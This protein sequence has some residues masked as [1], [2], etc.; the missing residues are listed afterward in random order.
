MFV[1]YDW[2]FPYIKARK[3]RYFGHVVRKSGDCSEKEI[4]QGR[5]GRRRKGRPKTSR[6][7][8][9][10]SWTG[11]RRDRLMR[12]VDE[13]LQWRQI[14]HSAANTR[15]I[16][17]RSMTLVEWTEVTR[18]SLSFIR[19][20]TLASLVQWSRTVRTRWACRRMWT[21]VRVLTPGSGCVPRRECSALPHTHTSDNHS[22]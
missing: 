5:A 17:L 19:R 8:N 21:C 12:Q 20:G 16:L 10:T 22:S 6:I 2:P 1:F 11:L 7:R 14:V 18:D 15:T 13:R 4:I 3:L 9:I